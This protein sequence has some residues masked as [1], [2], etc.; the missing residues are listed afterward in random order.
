MKH[1]MIGAATIS[2]FF[3]GLLHAGRTATKLQHMHQKIGKELIAIRKD[4][5]TVQSKVYALLDQVGSLY[6]LSVKVIDKKKKVKQLLQEEK[7]VAFT[8]RQNS[9]QL[10]G[11][12]VTLKCTIAKQEEQFSDY[13]QRF[14]SL[15]QEH[16][17]LTKEYANLQERVR[18]YEGQ[19]EGFQKMEREGQ[20]DGKS[21]AMNKKAHTQKKKR[22]YM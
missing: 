6:R 9:D 8:R 3:A 7:Q 2:V 22:A 10:R 16:Q 14:D 11:E 21:V 19:L 5:P 17:K 13:Q 12:V 20:T 18:V 4:H 15:A 1:I